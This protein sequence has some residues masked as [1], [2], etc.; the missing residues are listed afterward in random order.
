MRHI[1]GGLLEVLSSEKLG[2]GSPSSNIAS[3]GHAE[4]DRLSSEAVKLIHK[5]AETYLT[6]HGWTR[7]DEHAMD[8]CSLW[9]RVCVLTIEEAMSRTVRQ[10]PSLTWQELRGW[11]ERKGWEDWQDDKAKAFPSVF[12]PYTSSLLHH[13]LAFIFELCEGLRRILWCV[14]S[15]RDHHSHAAY[16][17]IV[18]LPGIVRIL[19]RPARQGAHY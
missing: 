19:L 17:S 18:A 3:D 15:E 5:S 14:K 4:D 8:T 2:N 6:N 12:M 9:M 11:E 13:S 7:F 10:S 1:T 16:S